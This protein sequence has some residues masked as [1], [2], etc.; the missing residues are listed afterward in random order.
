MVVNLV[1]TIEYLKEREFWIYGADAEAQSDIRTPDYE[2]HIALVM[3]SEGRGI[4]PLIRK[5]CDFLISI[6]MRGQVASLNVSVAA[7]VILFEI[8]RKWGN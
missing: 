5:N 2:G 4:R 7:G 6:P 8:L 3:G 1:R